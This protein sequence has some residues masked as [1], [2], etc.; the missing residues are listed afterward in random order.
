MI[1]NGI[2]I[3]IGDGCNTCFGKTYGWGSLASRINFQGYFL[4]HY[5]KISWSLIVVFG[6]ELFGIGT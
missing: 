2:H 1:V 3:L 6:M 5:R 4:C